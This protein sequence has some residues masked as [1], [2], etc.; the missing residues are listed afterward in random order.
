MI[1]AYGFSFVLLFSNPMV[2][3]RGTVAMYSL[4]AGNPGDY[5]WD[6][7]WVNEGEIRGG[8]NGY[9]TAARL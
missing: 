4:N 6:R 2:Q 7:L 9:D 8:M 5:L 1:V 3:E